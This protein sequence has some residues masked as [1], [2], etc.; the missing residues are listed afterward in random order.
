MDVVLNKIKAI[1]RKY[2]RKPQCY[3]VA[4]ILS[5]NFGGMIWYDSN[6][7]ITQIGEEFYDK[8]GLVPIEEIEN[9]NYIPLHQYGMDIE[10][11]L[12]VAA[13]KSLSL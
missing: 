8:R 5:G 7:C 13:Q 10:H 1:K 12:I 2:G 4:T 9:G 3:V 6:H 11:Q